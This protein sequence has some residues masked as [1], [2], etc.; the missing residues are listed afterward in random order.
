MTGE[1]VREAFNNNKKSR[2]LAKSD[3][4]KTDNNPFTLSADE[5]RVKDIRLG[6]D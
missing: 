1:K 4:N 2:T 3:S 5:K 6:P